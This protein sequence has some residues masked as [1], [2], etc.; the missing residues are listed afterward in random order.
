[1]YIYFWSRLHLYRI[2][3]FKSSVAFVDATGAF[4][5]LPDSYLQATSTVAG[6]LLHLGMNLACCGLA[7]RPRRSDDRIS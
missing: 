2:D 6:F 3:Y 7:A 4:P 5:P 1:M